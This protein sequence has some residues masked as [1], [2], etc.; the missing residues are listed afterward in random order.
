MEDAAQEEAVAQVVVEDGQFID[1]A[2]VTL[3]QA[4]HGGD[5]AG[6]ARARQRQDELL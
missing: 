3:K 5:L 4:D 2:A 1:V 6:C